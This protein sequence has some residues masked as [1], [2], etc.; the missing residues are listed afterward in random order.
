MTLYQKDHQQQISM[1]HLAALLYDV[2]VE[3]TGLVCNGRT[4]RSIGDSTWDNAISIS[5][6]ELCLVT[7]VSLTA[8]L[9]A[10]CKNYTLG[11]DFTMVFSV[12]SSRPERV[13]DGPPSRVKGSGF[14]QA[15]PSKAAF[16]D[17]FLLRKLKPAPV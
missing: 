10:S 11:D 12:A 14:S 6:S 7:G 9:L 13:Y 3:C 1:A 5:Y 15:W 8:E 4:V 16:S 17:L 2:L